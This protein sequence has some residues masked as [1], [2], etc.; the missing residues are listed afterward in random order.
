LKGK[1]KST[2]LHLSILLAF[3]DGSLGGRCGPHTDDEYCNGIS[4]VV[5]NGPVIPNHEKRKWTE[6][7]ACELC[8]CVHFYIIVK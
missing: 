2:V 7:G 3:V 5:E 6:Q 4:K 1:M 8:F